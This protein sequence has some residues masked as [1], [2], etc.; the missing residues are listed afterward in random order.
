[1]RGS[2][3]RDTVRPRVNDVG[4]CDWD[5]L[6]RG[7]DDDAAGVGG[8]DVGVGLDAAVGLSGTG[9]GGAG[10]LGGATSATGRAAVGLGAGRGEVGARGRGGYTHERHV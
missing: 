5:R 9:C 1:M 8:A 3:G 10:G 7:L 6:A 2:S 4:S